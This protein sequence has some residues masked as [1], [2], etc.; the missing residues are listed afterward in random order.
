MPAGRY[1]ITAEQGATFK[2][3]LE[4][5]DSTGTA[6]SLSGFTSRMDVKKYIGDSEFLLQINGTTG[7]GGVTGGGS[8]GFYLSG[9]GF[10]ASGGMTLNSSVTGAAGVTGGIFTEISAAAMANIPTGRHFYDIELVN[11]SEVTRI[12]EGKFDVRGEVSG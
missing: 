9:S 7:G 5:Q 3:F 2:L 4:Y 10:A 11:G 6:E 12:L 1:D 8:T